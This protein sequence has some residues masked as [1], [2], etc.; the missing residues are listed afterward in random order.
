MS[1]LVDQDTRVICQGLG[2]AG[3]FHTQQM[4]EYGTKVVAGVRPG[5]GGTTFEGIPVYDEIGPAVESTG[6]NTSVLFVPAPF[7]GQAMIDA[8]EAGIQL[9]VCIT[10]GVPTLD[11]LQAKR[12][13][14]ELGVRL[15]G[16][17]CP[18][19]ISPGQ[20]K[21]G[22]M[23]GYIHTAPC[24]AASGKCV[25]IISR[26]GTLTYE[27]VWQTSTLGI[28]QSTCIGVGGDPIKGENFIELLKR[29]EADEE[30]NGVVM[31]GEIG[32]SDEID[33]GFWV[34]EHM[35][36]PVI[37]FIAGRTAPRGKRMGHAG[38]IIGGSDDTATAKMESL[39][40]NGVLVTESPANIGA[41]TAEALGLTAHAG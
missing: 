3:Q 34:Q 38:A 11:V 12:R 24:D 14:N 19:I 1:I 10:E 25:G 41:M 33:A 9:V 8:A 15:I 20:C 7:V 37:A 21:I 32:G 18:G 36:K 6:A 35:T 31:I 30:T 22:I 5:K 4:L 13:L 17:N 28:G 2:R 40:T 23:P 39:Q 29:F 27:A 26:S 16:P